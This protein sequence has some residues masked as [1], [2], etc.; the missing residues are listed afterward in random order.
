MGFI[1]DE[2]RDLVKE[3]NKQ[4]ELLK[5][6]SNEEDKIREF[7]KRLEDMLAIMKR[8]DEAEIDTREL[9]EKMEEKLKDLTWSLHKR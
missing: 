8:L 5:I 6:S 4:T 3:H 7:E 2:V 1:L 9:R